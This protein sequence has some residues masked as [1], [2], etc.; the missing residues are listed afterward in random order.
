M[1]ITDYQNDVKYCKELLNFIHSEVGK[2][3]YS[4]EQI[5]SL[6]KEHKKVSFN[7]N[8][9][10]DI[11]K[12]QSDINLQ[13]EDL[14]KFDVL[15]R[16]IKD[17]FNNSNTLNKQIFSDIAR[18]NLKMKAYKIISYLDIHDATY[19]RYLANIESNLNRIGIKED[20][21][22]FKNKYGFIN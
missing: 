17:D 2:I 22:K 19:Y 14:Q 1:T 7:L 8:K 11:K 18:N 20:Y 21:I 10:Y 6:I 12:F 15:K 13:Q 4:N 9:E 3:N 5:I 16:I